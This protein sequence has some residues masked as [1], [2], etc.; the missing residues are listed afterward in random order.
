MQ[1]I[2]LVLLG[3]FL[4]G[5][6]LLGGSNNISNEIDGGIYRSVDGGNTW[7]HKISIPTTSEVK[8]TIGRI[9][10]VSITP[11]PQDR[12]ALY[13]STRRNGIYYTYSAA[14]SWIKA[15]VAEQSSITDIAV[16]P[17]SKCRIYAST[18]NQILRSNDC[19]RTWDGTY[20]LNDPNRVITAIDIAS[21]NTAVMYAGDASGSV[22]KSVDFGNSWKTVARFNNHIMHILVDPNASDVIY[23]A[24]QSKGLRKSIDAGESWIDLKDSLKEFKRSTSFRRL[25]FDPNSPDSLLYAS[26]YGILK[27]NNGGS[28]W[29]SIPLL[30]DERE[31]DIFG[32]AVHP[33]N[34]DIIYYSTLTTLFKTVDGG[35]TWAT[36]PLP[37]KRIPTSIHI[38]PVEPNV[39]Y[40]SVSNPLK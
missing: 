19:S 33:Q 18:G 2:K 38:D 32:I 40:M 13:L 37:T 20:I 16:D 30:T 3:I 9:D 21:F 17:Q 24:T 26:Q 22:F 39:I 11:D 10:I 1:Y 6:S 14:N 34:S 36:Q 23:V 35:E 31:A 15:P 8:P 5:C 12:L 27:T 4:T 7:E 28:S 29:T 25:I